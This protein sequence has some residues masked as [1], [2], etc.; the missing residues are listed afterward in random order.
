MLVLYNSKTNKFGCVLL[1]ALAGT[2]R[3]FLWRVNWDVNPEG[4]LVYEVTPEQLELL[5]ARNKGLTNVSS[6]L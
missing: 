5:I 6:K 4:M 1:A 2:E 3:N